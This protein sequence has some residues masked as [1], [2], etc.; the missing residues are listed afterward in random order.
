[1]YHV[2]LTN[3]YLTTR[4]IPLIAVAAV[5]LCVALVIIVVSVMTGF[6]NMVQNSGRTLVGDV[7]VTY[8]F[9]GVP[10]YDR[11]IDAIE[12][13]PEAEAATPVVD[14]FGLLKMPYPDGDKKQTETV[15]VWGVEPAGL[16]RVTGFHET[17]YWRN[18]TED[19][20]LEMG[21]G[22]FRR[23]LLDALGPDTMD[24]V[25][26]NGR[27][28]R[29]KRVDRG[30]TVLP[31]IVLGMHVSDGN[32]RQRDGSYRPVRGP[33]AFWWMPDFDVALTMV[34]V[35][36]GGGLEMKPV[37]KR[38][39]VVNEFVSGVFLIDDRRVIVPIEQAQEMLHFDESA[40]TDDEGEE[41]GFVD[42]PRATMVLVR[43]AE[44]VKPDEL[45]AAVVVTYGKF[46]SDLA[47]D[48][49]VHPD[50]VPPPP[51][52]PG[53]ISVQTW[54]QQ[55]RQF[56]DPIEKERELM[57]VLFSIIY[58]VCAGLV[59]SIFWAIVYEKTRDIGI[60][61][62]VGASR[63]GISAI[64]LR[65]GAIIGTVGAFLGLGISFLVVHNINAIHQAIGDPAPRWAV[66]TMFVVA[67]ASL[68]MT[69]VRS[70]GEF[71]LPVVLWSISTIV[72]AGL[73]SALLLHRGT[74]IWDPSVYYFSEIPNSMD[75][76]TAVTTMIGAVIFSVLGAF[77]PAMKAADTDPVRAL[78][79]E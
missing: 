12:A 64:F 41:T 78:R 36:T 2:L 14:G 26:E 72:F 39:Q 48:K 30:D 24:L 43:A 73:G 52:M 22:D 18:P 9:I 3:R 54:R 16:G 68:L 55:Q 13:L 74:L 44:G 69:I 56:I 6:L 45:R 23:G 42:P 76:V 31:A 47:R 57:R 61:R 38:F 70:F 75:V 35:T 62:S 1:M 4:V 5:A 77:I 11:L 66:I 20:L 49:T 40:I 25:G 28:L 79:Y 58:L 19:E 46:R 60:L 51:E 71:L 27:L 7:I 21:E 33:H 50:V 10:Y 63:M 32:E 59:L 53:A 37:T 17:L 65:Y 34:P 8:P 15:Q 29:H 67:A